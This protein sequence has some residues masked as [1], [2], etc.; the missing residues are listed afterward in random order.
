[1]KTWTRLPER[2]LAVLRDRETAGFLGISL[3]VGVAVG[4]GAALL[5]VVAESIAH[6]FVW[7]DER[8]FEGASWFVLIS[9]PV[10]VTL[11]WWIA[12]RFAPEVAGDGVPE[13]SAIF[14]NAHALA[15][16]AALCQEAGLVPMRWGKP[17]P[18]LRPAAGHR[19]RRSRRAVRS[20]SAARV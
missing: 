8:W 1:V 17:S 19:R 3:L 5:V 9:V 4:L 16:Y 2:G 12:R 20:A 13:A 18:P 7:V 10:G 14:A 15:R 11:A 6:M